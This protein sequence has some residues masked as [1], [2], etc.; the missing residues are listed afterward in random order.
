MFSFLKDFNFFVLP[1]LGVVLFES[2]VWHS[3]QS[4]TKLRSTMFLE[5]RTRQKSK[6]HVEVSQRSW[7]TMTRCFL[8]LGVVVQAMRMWWCFGCIA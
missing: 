8:L 1:T 5:K 3:W 7:T 6:R 4:K 2:D